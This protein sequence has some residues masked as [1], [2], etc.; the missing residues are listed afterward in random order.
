MLSINTNLSSLI[1]QQSLSSSTAKLNQAIERMSTGFKINH[2]KDNAANYSISTN[3]TTKI[4]AYMVAEDN[5]AMG[6]DML[7]TAE[8]SLNQ[9]S[10]K[11][12]RL[13]D[14]ATQAGNGTYGAQSLNAI[15]SEANALVDEIQRLYTTAEYN[16]IKLFGQ[17]Q[18]QQAVAAYGAR[19]ATVGGPGSFYTDEE[20]TA[21]T[22]VKDAAGFND[23]EYYTISTIEELCII[24][25]AI[26]NNRFAAEA[27]LVLTDD[28]DISSVPNWEPIDFEGACVFD[29]N[30]HVITGLTINTT[31]DNQGFFGYVRD[32]STIKNLGLEN[33]NIKGGD[34]TGGLVGN[35]YYTTIENCYV[36]GNVEGTNNVGGLVG[37]KDEE[38]PISNSYSMCNVLGDCHVGGLIGGAGD[39]SWGDVVNCFATG[40]ISGTE[41]VGGFLGS[42]GD[43]N[44]LMKNCF[45]TGDVSGTS[46][47]GGFI[48][49]LTWT[50]LN[51][52]YASGSVNGTNYVGGF[53]GDGWPTCINCASTQAD[54]Y[55]VNGITQMTAE[56]IAQT[57][58]PESMGFTEANGWTI[59][60]GQP[61]A[62]FSFAAAPRIP[63]GGALA[64]SNYITL[65]I[66]INSGESSGI[67]FDISFALGVIDD[68]R[69]IGL[70]TTT[71]YLTT[72]D[73]ML[74]TVNAKQTEFGAVENRLNSALDEISIRYE[75][76]VSSRS[77]IR[78]ADIAEVS[79]E[80]IRQQILQQASA[81]LLA[82]ANQS[83]S[84]ALQ[85]I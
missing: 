54:P 64:G 60:N 30:G 62:S 13:R 35:A 23:G 69:M 38:T 22:R 25:D 71:D 4:G 55:G 74:S 18:S 72:L 79:S 84:I 43:G 21:M 24:R 78:D 33:V 73:N 12:I 40:D 37:Y 10:D 53:I 28:I 70:D 67:G 50:E 45:A 66:G 7:S 11:L 75:N 2:A 9:I 14:L 46:Y 8:G 34:Y 17:E 39:S 47:V 6:L 42:T 48:G 19:T 16:G 31:A 29:G 65:Q 82:T 58:T 83:P 36:T 44:P 56:E 81:T 68:L 20:I 85:L 77:T 80:Y 1:A 3:L 49:G 5:V 63:A 59:V 26:N 57:Y 76:L 41:Y 61:V 51:D 15:N 52:C 32:N 27:I